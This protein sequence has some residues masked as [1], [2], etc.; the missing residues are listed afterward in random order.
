MTSFI[1][2]LT[3]VLV[4]AIAARLIIKKHNPVA[5]FLAI[6]IITLTIYSFV[7]GTSLVEASTG[8]L[9]FDVLK[10]VEEKMKSS[11]QGL[12]L[13]LMT[14]TGYAVYMSHTGAATKLALTA[15]KPLSKLNNP[16][17]VLSFVFIIGTI[18]K[19]VITSHSGLGLLMMATCFP[20]LIQL[21]VG[22][23]SAAATMT[24]VG[25][26]DWGPNDSSAIFAAKISEMEPVQY[27][28][29]YQAKVSICCILAMAVFLPIYFRKKDKEDKASNLDGIK[30]ENLEM[31]DLPVIYII[32]PAIP[33][34]LVSI[35]AFI[36]NI[37]MGIISANLIGFVVTF[38]LEIIRRKDIKA[39]G[40]D[41]P[42]ILK[43]MGTCFANIVSIIISAGVFAKS[44]IVLNGVSVL[45]DFLAGLG[46]GV[47][48]S[49]ILMS[50]IT[51]GAVMLLGSG[52]A[53]WYAF[54]PLVPNIAA[55]MGI[56]TAVIAV[57]MQLATAIGRSLSP[58]AGVVIA[59][60][61]LAEID[62]IDMIKRCVVPM[63][64]SFAV[65]II[66]SYIFVVLL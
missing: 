2:V 63:L 59:V 25:F 37:N 44:I 38:I 60:S 7:T 24:L 65:C 10:F 39:V 34:L 28:L 61:G 46:G 41:M 53:S 66:S 3:T 1:Q 58:V 33:L 42:V 11:T 51:F 49:M 19:L 57:P 20:I 48:I 62:S 8:N 15:T 64:V 6:G 17:I 4:I 36:P 29:T 54:G 18:L 13:I 5:V 50:L 22:K 32:L 47:I 14:V 52:N 35:F 31:P 45:G 16:Y 21:G 23:V 27:F 30:V 56:S 12:G 40:E 26:L 55:E 43:A 9:F